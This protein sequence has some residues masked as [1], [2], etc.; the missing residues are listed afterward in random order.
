MILGRRLLGI[1]LLLSAVIPSPSR[2]DLSGSVTPVSLAAGGVGSYIQC[3]CFRW[4]IGAR[5]AGGV[6]ETRDIVISSDAL[7]KFRMQEDLMWDQKPMV[8]MFEVGSL[9]LLLKGAHLGLAFPGV[10]FGEDV[11]K[12][13]SDF[14]Q[15][16]I[17]A[18]VNLIRTETIGLEA[19]TGYQ[20][21]QYRI[22][23]GPLLEEHEGYEAIVFNWRRGRWNGSLSGLMGFE[24]G[25][26]ERPHFLA[27]E[28]TRI[29]AFS[30]KDLQMGIALEFQAEHEPF[31]QRVGLEP[32]SVAATVWMDF[33]YIKQWKK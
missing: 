3:P 4:T 7:F 32:N 6:L 14:L 21:Q 24:N 16:G 26:Y 27:T 12:G 18:L 28:S 2:A 22:N 8:K 19:R 10:T 15:T 30:I 33:S 17:Y 25:D 1:F 29:R 5:A 31:R 9:R 23:L 20:Y 11:D 13:Y